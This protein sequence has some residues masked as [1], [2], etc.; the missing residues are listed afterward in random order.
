MFYLLICSGFPAVPHL[1][2]RI[3]SPRTAFASVHSHTH[4]LRPVCLFA[5]RAVLVTESAV[6]RHQGVLL[7]GPFGSSNPL[8]SIR[9]L[10]P[11][12]QLPPR[13]PPDSLTRAALNPEST[14][15][16]WQPATLRLPTHQPARLPCPSSGVSR[17]LLVPRVRL[18]HVPQ[19]C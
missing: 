17:C 2:K 15:A 18:S 11:A 5:S 16:N 8:I 9:V 7:R 13:H 10:E 12:C 1:W 3:L 4:S 14:G 6:R 19:Q